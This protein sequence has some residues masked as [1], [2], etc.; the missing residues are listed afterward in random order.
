MK[1]KISVM[2]VLPVLTLILFFLLVFNGVSIGASLTLSISIS[3]AIAFEIYLYF[4]DKDKRKELEKLNN[5][6]NGL[7]KEPHIKENESIPEEK[8]KHKPERT[9]YFLF[10]F[11][12]I[13]YLTFITVIIIGMAT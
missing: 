4:D 1:I 8:Q 7:K 11:S 6:I 10:T 13:W 2:I 12:I 3:F 5:R 9:L